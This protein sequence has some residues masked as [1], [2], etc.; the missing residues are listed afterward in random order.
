[1]NIQYG[2]G[3]SSPEGWVNFDSSPTLRLQK[4]PLIGACCRGG[5]FPDFPA[6]VRYGNIVKGLPVD[7][8]LADY[9]YCS[10]VLEHLALEDFRCALKNT[11]SLLKPGGIFRFVLPDLEYYIKEYSES[12]S[13]T[14]SIGFM[15]DTMLGL[16]KRSTGLEGL[17]R[18][19]IGGSKHLWMWDFL[20]MKEELCSAGFIEI[21]RA[22]FGD[23][24]IKVFDDVENLGRW[25]VNLG[26][27][28]CRPA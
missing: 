23:S 4:F 17:L 3:L 18:S 6:T 8:G 7:A 10:H 1:M 26:V 22:H 27:Q 11:Y 15:T 16:N 14:R 24:G 21:R 25:G 5:R 9:V 12:E 19:W 2:C 28:C 20:S 13:K